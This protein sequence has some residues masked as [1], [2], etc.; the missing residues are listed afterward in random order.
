MTKNFAQIRSKSCK[1]Y[2]ARHLKIAII[3]CKKKFRA[4]SQ[5]RFKTNCMLASFRSTSVDQYTST[6][7]SKTPIKL[8]E[9]EAPEHVS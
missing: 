2:G 3:T 8:F 5:L 7:T 4:L 1:Q 6:S 9:P